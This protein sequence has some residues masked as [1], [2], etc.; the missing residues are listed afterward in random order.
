MRD[1]LGIG[2]TPPEEQC[3]QIGAKDYDY[4][5]MGRFECE[6]Y[7]KVLVEAMGE[8]PEGARLKIK[9]NYHEFG[10]YYEV[11]C[12]YEDSFQAA[13]EYAFKC[14]SEGPTHWPEW[15]KKAVK[16]AYLELG[17]D[18]TGKKIP[19]PTNMSHFSRLKMTVGDVL[20]FKN[21]KPRHFDEDI[22]D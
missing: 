14:E 1:Y 4:H 19:K 13:I 15:A 16:T 18:E 3:A 21:K 7:K 20:E 2:P 22:I 6:L 12:W 5:V 10:T 9:S 17:C 8:P 11:V